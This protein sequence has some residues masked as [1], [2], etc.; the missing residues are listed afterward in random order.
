MLTKFCQQVASCPEKKECRWRQQQLTINK[1]N[2]KIQF[3]NNSLIL[4]PIIVLQTIISRQLYQTSSTP[5]TISIYP[6]LF[7]VTTNKMIIKQTISDLVL[8]ALKIIKEQYHILHRSDSNKNETINWLQDLSLHISCGTT[9][10]SLTSKDQT[11]RKKDSSSTL[12]FE[13]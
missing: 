2:N 8:H 9:K 6:I 4:N 12:S 13:D 11:T 7:T 10:D 5:T 3:L 1:N